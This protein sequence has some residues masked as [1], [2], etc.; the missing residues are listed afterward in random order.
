M[1]G[2]IQGQTVNHL[3][4]AVCNIISPLD[5][6]VLRRMYA[7]TNWFSA[8]PYWPLCSVHRTFTILAGRV[9][10]SIEWWSEVT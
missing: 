7:T 5:G 8:R 2:D 3:K 6:V 1:K 10:I 4:V 9:I